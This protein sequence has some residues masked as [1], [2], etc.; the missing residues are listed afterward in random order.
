MSLRPYAAAQG[1]LRAV[2]DDAEDKGV[3]SCSTPHRLVVQEPSGH[4]LAELGDASAAAIRDAEVVEPSDIRKV[5]VMLR[6]RRMG[7]CRGRRGGG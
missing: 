1:E 5:C 6:R 4:P 2:V 3:T 7:H